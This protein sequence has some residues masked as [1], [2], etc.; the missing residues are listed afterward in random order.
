MR[1]QIPENWSLKRWRICR[2]SKFYLKNSEEISFISKN[3]IFND[4]VI[5]EQNKFNIFSKK[6][7][8]RGGILLPRGDPKIVCPPP[9]LNPLY[10]PDLRI[11]YTWI[12]RE[13][14]ICDRLKHL[15]W[16]WLRRSLGIFYTRISKITNNNILSQWKHECHRGLTYE[17]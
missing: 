10:A 3:I 4:A 11:M 8:L 2:W 12:G 17:A 6:G 14:R 7:F 15:G 16:K 1:K 9:K 13:D 5:I